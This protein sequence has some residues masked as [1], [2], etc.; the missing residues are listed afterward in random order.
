M[1]KVR[2]SCT[3]ILIVKEHNQ[4]TNN[5]SLVLLSLKGYEAIKTL[6][7]T[8]EDPFHYAQLLKKLNIQQE[9]RSKI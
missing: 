6:L 8:M 9:L 7:E 2:N 5:E 3:P 1:N 4:L